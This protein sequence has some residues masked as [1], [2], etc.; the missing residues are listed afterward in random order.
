MC[1]RTVY[2]FI[3]LQYY[4]HIRVDVNYTKRLDNIGALFEQGMRVSSMPI[5][6]R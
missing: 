1:V 3:D 6:H 4:K 2:T 5:D